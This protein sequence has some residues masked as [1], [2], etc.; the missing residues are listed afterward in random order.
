MGAVNG[1]VDTAL[2]TLYSSVPPPEYIIVTMAP[3]RIRRKPPGRNLVDCSAPNA[4]FAWSKRASTPS[5]H[6][7]RKGSASCFVLTA[8]TVKVTSPILPISCI[9][10][11]SGEPAKGKSTITGAG[12]T[13]Q[14]QAPL[15]TLT[16][17]VLACNWLLRPTRQAK[18]TSKSL[19]KSFHF[20]PR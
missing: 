9:P 7:A 1:E 19:R 10:G 18:T 8:A 6:V 13:I 4:R 2:L 17:A 15:A 14:C 16:Q 11:S 5:V 3:V 12:I 20:S